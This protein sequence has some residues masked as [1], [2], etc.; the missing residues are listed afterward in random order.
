MRRVLRLIAIETRAQWRSVVPSRYARVAI[1]TFCVAWCTASTYLVV[2]AVRGNPRSRADALAPLMA[3]FAGTAL[4]VSMAA[5]ARTLERPE[6]FAVWRLA[7]VPP[8]WSVAVPL[9]ASAAL[10]SAAT[11]TIAMPAIVA[12]AMGHALQAVVVTAL[13]LIVALWIQIAAVAILA[14][15]AAHSGVA[16]AARAGRTSAGPI[17][18]LMLVVMRLAATNARHIDQVMLAG[19]CIGSA[20]LLPAAMRTSAGRWSSALSLGAP[21]RRSPRP[22]WGSPSWWRLM[23]RTPFAWSMLGVAPLVAWSGTATLN[24]VTLFALM[25]PSAAMFHLI[26]WEDD[27]PDRQHLAPAGERVRLGLWLHVGL[28]V[29]LIATAVGIG[30][31]QEPARIIVFAIA[32]WTGALL[33]LMPQPRLRAALQLALIAIAMM[34]L[35]SPAT[36]RAQARDPGAIAENKPTAVLK[37]TVFAAHSGMPVARARV[38]LVASADRQSTTVAADAKGAFE[39]RGVRPGRY[40]ISATKGGFVPTQFGQR[41]AFVA[42]KPIDVAGGTEIERLDIHLIP[43]ASI[44]G[45]VVDEFGEPVVDAVMMT[46]RTQYA[47]GSKRLAATGRVL[48]TNDKGEF[49]LFGLPPGT[50]FL[51]ASSMTGQNAGDAAGR[52]G[53]APTYFPGSVDLASAQPIV[54]DEGEQ[55][56]GADVV[57]NLVK[58]ASISGSARDPRGAPFASGAVTV[59]NLVS[60]F[61]IPVATGAVLADGTFR[62]QNVPPGS[63]TV[64]AAAAPGPD[65]TRHTATLR[66]VV[67]GEDI[68]G[69]VLAAPQPSTISGW[70]GREA[71]DGEPLPPTVQLRLAPGDPVDDLGDA[72][73][74]VRTN[75]D[76]SFAS[77]A[78]PGRVRFELID[79][80]GWFISRVLHGS[81]DITDAGLLIEADPIDNVR[82]MLTRNITTVNGEVVVGAS[83]QRSHDYT[84]VI[85]PR[86]RSLWTYRSR[87]IATARPDQQGAFSIKGLPAGDY[88]IAAID[89]VEQG[90]GHDAEFLESIHGL[91]Q[92][93]SLRA[94]ES[95]R[96]T[97][98]VASRP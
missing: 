15:V 33:F 32:T 47:G 23:A 79:G 49:H 54:L 59:V 11:L 46:L 20:A 58:T 87:Y 27:C 26:Q 97:L 18:A 52:E 13:A 41:R 24:I 25:L 84:V 6:R 62:I 43:G 63:F 57:L 3:L 67:R 68:D 31:L 92:T 65:G 28:P 45:R 75:A 55:R 77:G 94:G 76:R 61:A 14:A 93:V 36:A 17:A 69:L 19:L 22:R 44:D 4:T 51:S 29:S 16:A 50:Y 71:T 66:V 81:H 38:R 2:A 7:P 1:V 56:A 37:G 64:V 74:L 30:V 5:I 35:F 40:Q 60:G 53:Y 91:A 88:L 70:I 12:A 83:R 86:D 8:A 78:R 82:V 10:S 80:R 72:G 96:I 48:T 21:R 90:E 39:F 73:T 98:T 89:H 95:E 85:F 34:L 42:G 9:T